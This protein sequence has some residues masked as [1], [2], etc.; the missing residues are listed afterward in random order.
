M[1][2]SRHGIAARVAVVALVGLD[3]AVG[4]ETAFREVA[5]LVVG[6]RGH[7]LH[8]SNVVVAEPFESRVVFGRGFH[9]GLAATTVPDERHADSCEALRGAA[10]F[11]RVVISK[12]FPQR[13]HRFGQPFA[14]HVTSGFRVEAFVGFAAIGAELFEVVAF[15]TNCSGGGGPARSLG[16]E[17]RGAGKHGLHFGGDREHG[18]TKE[19]MRMLPGTSSEKCLSVQCATERALS[20]RNT[21]QGADHGCRRC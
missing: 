7:P 20:N 12:Q 2:H 3:P 18:S 8:Q 19:E 21:T 14:N 16:A 13:E 5:K 15:V 4:L 10:S 17:F 6:L 11:A 1:W 9:L